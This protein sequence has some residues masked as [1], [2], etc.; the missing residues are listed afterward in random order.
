MSAAEAL[1]REGDGRLEVELFE[2]KR[3]AGGRAGSFTDAN[4]GE[5]VDY[6]QHV[7]MGCCT[8]LIGLLERCGQLRHW[9]RYSELEF[10]HLDFPPSRFSPSPWLPPPLHLL[11]GLVRLSHL[12]V[13]AKRKIARG[14]WKLMRTHT[15]QLCHTTAAEW[16]SQNGQDVDTNEGFWNVIL[17]SAL[18]ETPDRVSMAA[19]RKVLI[20]GFVAARGAA[21]VLVP[22]KPLSELF[23]RDL[24][25]VLRSIG[26]RT[27][28]SSRIGALRRR[29]DGRVELIAADGVLAVADHVILATPWYVSARLLT[30]HLPHA[31][32]ETMAAIEGS[33]ISGVHLW[34]DRE[35]T[36]R[37][38]TVMI[39]GVSQWLFRPRF[40]AD[41]N[42]YYQV[43]ISASSEVRDRAKSD[44]VSEVVKEVKTCFPE[45]ED[46]VLLRG[47]V[48]TDPRSVFS[49]RPSI[50]QVRPPSSTALPWLH[51]A[52]DW[53]ATGWPSTMEGAVISGRMAAST[54][55]R[56][57]GRREVRV[58]PGL[59]RG[60]IANW[61]IKT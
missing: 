10:R 12:D 43:V 41:A 35:I 54:V 37:P 28:T 53:I 23:G 32:V 20:D 57:L 24:P 30:G 38:H 16:L 5:S 60:R 61:I 56:Q 21:D 44:V 33:P 2:S 26:V 50:D 55:A 58:D 29:E 48:V 1:M 15:S 31:A 7:A 9:T 40:G 14:V 17:V 34:F 19:A 47:L 4:S 39:G 52:G 3:S 13:A 22:R 36:D 6:C 51:L 27:G 42:P 45:A 59:P 25:E 18:G 8:N 46:A 49:V 11:G